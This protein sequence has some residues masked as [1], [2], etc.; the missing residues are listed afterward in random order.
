MQ[1]NFVKTKLKKIIIGNHKYQLT[2]NYQ[3]EFD[4][5]IRNQ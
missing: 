1:K 4:K 3:H 5:A 2:V